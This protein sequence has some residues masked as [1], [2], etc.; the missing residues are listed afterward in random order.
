MVNCSI[1]YITEQNVFGTVQ[2]Y[3]FIETFL[4]RDLDSIIVISAMYRIEYICSMKI[5]TMDRNI[6][7]IQ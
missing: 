2:L 7:K 5:F 6:V 3:I 4:I 1:I